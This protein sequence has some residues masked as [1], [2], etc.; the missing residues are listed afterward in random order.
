M[1]SLACDSSMPRF[2]SIL[3]CT[4]DSA[5]VKKSDIAHNPSACR[6]LPLQFFQKVLSQAG[7]EPM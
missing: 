1:A 5:E 7:A 6:S 3:F 2:W 4:E